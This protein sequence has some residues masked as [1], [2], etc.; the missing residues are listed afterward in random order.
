[1]I[2][3]GQITINKNIT[4]VKNKPKNIE[5]Y[6]W[7][8]MSVFSRRHFG[9]RTFWSLWFGAGCFGIRLLDP[10]YCDENYFR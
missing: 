8:S 2:S 10:R 9:V 3:H 7:K 5:H 6:T 1:K 4:E